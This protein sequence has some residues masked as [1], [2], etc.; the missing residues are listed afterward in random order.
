MDLSKT[1]DRPGEYL[2][3]T[4]SLVAF[5]ISFI[6]LKLWI[7]D[8]AKTTSSVGLHMLMSS[9]FGLTLASLG[10]WMAVGKL[11]IGSFLTGIAIILTG[12][13]T[14]FNC[15]HAFCKNDDFFL[16]ELSP[17]A[18]YCLATLG[19]ANIASYFN[20]NRRLIKVV[21][22]LLL[23]SIAVTSISIIGYFFGA[24]KLF[25]IPGFSPIYP[26]TAAVCFLLTLG[27]LILD[28]TE[29][30]LVKTFSGNRLASDWTKRLLIPA[31]VMP[32]AIGYFGLW[33]QDRHYLSFGES[34]GLVVWVLGLSFFL[35][36][37]KAGIKINMIDE[38]RIK[39]FEQAEQ[40][41]KFLKNTTDILPAFIAYYDSEGTYCFANQAHSDWL[42]MPMDKI[43]GRNVRDLWES[44]LPEPYMSILN[45]AFKGE[46]QTFE[47]EINRFAK[48]K[49]LKAEMIPDKNSQGQTL[50][51]Y[52]LA[53]DI[54]DSINAIKARDEFL[55]IASHELRTPLTSLKLQTELREMGFE[56][57]GMEFFSPAK[58]EN[59]ITSDSRQI[60]RL[61]R[62]ID[63]MLDSTRIGSGQ[64]NLRKVEDDY[65]DLAIQVVQRLKSHFSEGQLTLRTETDSVILGEFDI[66][67][68]EQVLVN[69]VLN[70]QKYGGPA[71]FKF[72]SLK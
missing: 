50:G 6:M 35:F 56:K 29:S 14:L 33:I 39:A 65:I 53:F 24:P 28:H 59:M 63:D 47:I 70:A 2:A 51:V 4:L 27:H 8:A 64:L 31:V 52:A 72:L 46:R 49:V 38:A 66:S 45:K 36:V 42:Q 7:V 12:V 19:V 58:I 55:S 43:I 68:M 11:R 21:R 60:E 3:K 25:S 61:T 15:S 10:L 57:G 13:A 34:M 1:K 9:A 26:M 17:F 16:G 54:T 37:W 20:Q 69:L 67:R 18:A 5:L 30:S 41:A 40:S 22:L 62:L 48:T 23:G 44:D 71:L 32:I